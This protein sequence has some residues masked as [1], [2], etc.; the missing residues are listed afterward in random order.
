MAP[1]VVAQASGGLLD[2]LVRHRTAANLILCLMILGGV[3]GAANLRA[4]FF[5]DVVL[6][7]LSVS[8]QWPG[9]GPEDVDRSIVAVLQ[10]SLMAVEGV[11]ETSSVARENRATITLDFEAGWDMGRA[12]D[13]VKAV[14]D[15]ERNLPEGAEEPEIRRRAWRDRVTD[16]VLH[17]PV[18]F[19]LLSQYAEEFRARLFE[20]GA[21][22]TTLRGVADPVIRIAIPEAKLI[23]YDLTLSEVAQVVTSES[24]TAPAGDLGAGSARLRTGTE[25]RTADT[26]SSIAIRSLPDG[27][28]LYLRDV[29]NVGVEGVE[30]G[31]AYFRRGDPAI[32][33]EVDRSDKGDAIKLQALVEAA[34][35]DIRATLPE[36][37]VI[38]LT[39]TR[40]EA[41]SDRLNILIKNG[42]MGLALVLVFLFLFLSARTAFWVAI[43]IPAA[44]AATLGL[45]YAFGLTLNMVSLFGLII[46]LGVV[47]DDAIVVGEHADFLARRRGLAPAAA[48]ATAAR[49]MAAPVFSASITTVIAFSALTFIGDRFGN[50]IADV[51]FTVS[52]V[53]IASLAESFLVLP[54]HM[55]HA[56]SA[57][58]REPWYDWPSRTVNRGFRWFRDRIFRRIVALVI[59]MRYPAVGAAIMVLLISVSLLIDGR[60]PWRFFNAPERGTIS[61]NIAMLPGASRDD[62]KAMLAEMQRALEVV[63]ARYRETHG[64]APVVFSLE[65]VGRGAGRGLRSAED[66]DVDLLGG[67]SI[68]LIDPDDR[69][70]SAFEFIADWQD[71]IQKHRL[72][73]T[74][75]LRGRRFG[76]GGDA[77]DI[78]LSGSDA[79]TLKAAAELLKQKLAAYP[80][81]SALED[82]LAYD[83]DELLLNLTPRGEALGFNTDQIG[84]ELFNRLRGIDAAEFPLGMQTG[85]IRVSLP[86]SELDASFLSRTRIRSSSGAFVP[87]SEIVS[88]D[89]KLG[90]SSVRRE[91][92]SR[93]IRVTGDISEDDP[94]LAARVMASLASEILPDVASI[95]GIAWDLGGLAEQERGFLADAKLGFT[96]CLAGIYLT[97]A[98]IFGSWFRPIVVMAIIPF[99]M[100][101][102][103][104]GHHWHGIPLSMFSII[105]F[106]GLSG[107]II[108]DSIVLVT[109]IEEY[110]RR[111]PI[112][113]AIVEGVCDR[114]RPVLL[115]T[116]TTVFGLAPLLFEQSRQAQ[117]LL[118]MVIT[119]AYGLGFG[120]VLVLVVTPALLAIQ[121]DI[122]SAVTSGRRLARLMAGVRMR[123]PAGSPDQPVPSIRE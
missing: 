52:M 11:E 13:E 5:P 111:K 113:W 117:F 100:V 92:G 59:R 68:E 109:T 88:V 103:V 87:L 119:L 33:V 108:N 40:A 90:F 55:R 79:D 107:I 29:A 19:D 110:A 7:S 62:T 25:R 21:T 17:G 60:L 3:Y 23:Q 63:D 83:K 118:P 27:S 30:R 34:A 123:R 20:A 15:T 104:W 93:V 91:N 28:K 18:G 69:S 80:G 48:A 39:R 65:T 41:I 50:L 43:G 37:V 56:L 32:I 10:P 94:D 36:G 42:A 115:T 114:L 35:D 73:E 54:A 61:A 116:L 64:T 58:N 24:E 95:H 51:P 57:K 76:P 71:E 74:L 45:M 72:L 14:I 66:K 31:V 96:I 122:G 78:K 89:S 101:G 22:R 67:F 53:L 86:E 2:Y 12:T 99:G 4:Q 84:T 106:I 70:Y 85:T 44:M 102:M 16:V 38:Q 81:V 9:A 82:T 105:G 98:W 97:L 26:L 46:C 121:R 112:H 6:E 47:V 1:P 49:R 77:I 75:A 120:L 8:V